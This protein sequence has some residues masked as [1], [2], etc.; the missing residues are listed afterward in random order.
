VN[1]ISRISITFHGV[2]GLHGKLKQKEESLPVARNIDIET[3]HFWFP[4]AGSWRMGCLVFIAFF[5]TFM[6]KTL[7]F[8]VN[9][10]T[11]PTRLTLVKRNQDWKQG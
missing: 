1:N 5:A 10:L 8:A 4:H 7:P 3:F 6:V 9:L 11:G 2:I